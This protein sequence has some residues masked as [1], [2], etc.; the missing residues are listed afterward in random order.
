MSEN[1]RFSCLFVADA[2]IWIRS[3]P[4]ETPVICQV[5]IV[6]PVAILATVTVDGDDENR[7]FCELSVTDRLD[8]WLF[9]GAL[10]T[11]A[12]ATFTVWV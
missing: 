11:F 7:P 9:V 10:L 5:T 1:L 12:T 4:A 8:N 6:V 3:E 2:D